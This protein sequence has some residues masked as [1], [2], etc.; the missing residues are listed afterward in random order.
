MTDIMPDLTFVLHG[1]CPAVSAE[2]ASPIYA[3]T[4]PGSRH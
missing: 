3:A 4:V 2:V 1:L